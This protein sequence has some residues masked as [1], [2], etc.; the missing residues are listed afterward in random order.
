MNQRNIIILSAPS[1]T[2]KSSIIQLLLKSNPGFAFSIST[3]TRSPRPGEKEGKDYYFV[4]EEEFKAMIDRDEFVEWAQV[5]ANYYGTTRREVKRILSQNLICLLD[6]DVQGA[7]N[8][9]K[10]YPDAKAVFILPPSLSELK[11][12]LL[13]RGDTS[14][15]QIELRLENAKKELAYISF[16]HYFVVN[17]DLGK[18]VHM[19]QTH[20]HEN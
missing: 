4:S 11:K 2:G 9:L 7:V 17:D 20:I 19:I 3:T 15:E 13:K 8:I 5:H 12:R 1:G 10:I 14:L 6:I 18:A 16:Y